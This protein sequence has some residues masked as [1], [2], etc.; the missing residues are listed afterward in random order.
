MPRD[1]RFYLYYALWGIALT[2]MLYVIFVVMDHLFHM[3][4]AALLL[5]LDFLLDPDATPFVL[6]LL[7]HL[8]ITLV[9]LAVSLWVDRHRDWSFKGWLAILA[10]FF[11]ALY[12]LMIW[13]S[14]REIFQYHFGAHVLWSVG[15]F[16]FLGLMAGVVKHSRRFE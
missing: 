12:P 11:V 15:H 16:I 7:C 5:N 9:I 10:I 8:C 13:L 14:Q 4:L 2:L 6:E 1:K 3:H